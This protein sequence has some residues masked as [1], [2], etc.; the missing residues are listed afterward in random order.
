MKDSVTDLTTQ[1]LG[2]TTVG[3]SG[4]QRLLILLGALAAL[5]FILVWAAL[6]PEPR[7][8]KPPGL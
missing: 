2:A 1:A 5:P 4:P 3:L 7:R 6:F 8:P